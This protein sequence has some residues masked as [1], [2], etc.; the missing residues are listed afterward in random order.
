MA[1]D[2]ADEMSGAGRS[3]AGSRLI[4]GVPVSELFALVC[5][6]GLCRAWA[7][8]AL[9]LAAQPAGGLLRY[10]EA[11]LFAGV[12]ALLAVALIAPRAFAA[13]S[14]LRR[15]GIALI[16][17]AALALASM[18]AALLSG[19]DGVLCVAYVL[20][21]A[22]SGLLQVLWGERFVLAGVR[23]ALLATP[24]AAVVVAL[25]L[26][27]VSDLLDTPFFFGALP[28]TVALLFLG[29]R[30]ILARASVLAD[31]NGSGPSLPASALAASVRPAG[32]PGVAAPV[33]SGMLV[34]LMTSIAVFSLIGR[35]LD[36][37]PVGDAE[38]VPQFVA[39]NYLYLGILAAGVLFCGL[40]VALGRRFDTLLVYRLSLP[41]M[42]AGFVV[43]TLFMESFTVGSVFVVTA[44]YE[45]F[46]LLFWTMLVAVVL[47]GGRSAFAVFAWGVAAT[48]LGMGLGMMTSRVAV[49]LIAAGSVPISSF[50]LVS[51]LVL[52]IL[53]VLVLPEGTLSKV[54]R[55]GRPHVVRMDDAAFSR[56]CARVAEAHGLT[57]R[58]G[59]VL[60]L[61]GRGRTLAVVA[62]ELGIAEGTARTHMGHIYA[63]LGVHRQQELID[64]IEAEP[65]PEED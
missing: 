29:R 19:A 2:M 1:R 52:V 53:V 55:A 45:F 62:R 12:L 56:R 7:V 35:C 33:P 27:G 25:L 58:E 36:S 31:P 54:G 37:F 63:K 43:L 50:S 20:A 49:E 46:E 21:G 5:G 57:R 6:F 24:G 40:V 26:M 34:R 4:A 32:M 22:T 11:M 8:G 15:M 48:Y 13:P 38:L 59:D 9:S 3:A 14:G 42:V 61:L 41:L 47:R 44:G 23:G 30:G 17:L 28:V 10:D 64:L 39:Q 18:T 51:I 16:V 65:L 60:E